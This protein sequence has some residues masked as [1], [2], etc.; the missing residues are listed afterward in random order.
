MTCTFGVVVLG[1]FVRG[2]ARQTIPQIRFLES[3][4]P[5]CHK[6]LLLCICLSHLVMLHLGF[7]GKE[8]TQYE[9]NLKKLS[10]KVLVQASI[11]KPGSDI[12]FNNVL[13]SFSLD[14]L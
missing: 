4:G 1:G 3:Q 12:Q 6:H 11:I 14:S 5:R 8:V 2:S 10:F 9:L 7:S 13:V